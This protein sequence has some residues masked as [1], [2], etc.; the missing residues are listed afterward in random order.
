MIEQLPVALKTRGK[1][2]ML[3][4]I[5]IGKVKKGGNEGEPKP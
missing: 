5:E 1:Q 4:R 3:I 2:K